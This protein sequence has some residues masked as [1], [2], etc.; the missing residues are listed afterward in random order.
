MVIDAAEAIKK[1]FLLCKFVMC[2]FHVAP[3]VEVAASI[4][5]S[6]SETKM[7]GRP[8]KTVN[9]IVS[10]IAGRKGSTNY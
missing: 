10:G 8:P 2:C 5:T 3:T 6:S 7:R 9:G 4:S 1:T